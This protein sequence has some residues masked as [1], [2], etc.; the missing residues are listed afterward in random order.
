[1]FNVKQIIWRL[2][3]K[4]EKAYYL[5]VLRVLVSLWFIK[6]MFFRWPAFEMLYSNHSFLK[7]DATAS[8][9]AFGLNAHFLREHYIVLITVCMLLLL[10]NLFG[11]G[12]NITS[13]LLFLSFTVLY[14]LD[15]KFANSGDEMSML[16]LF[17]LSF[18]NSFSYFTL[19]KRKPFESQKE[20]VYNLISNLAAYSMMINLCLSYFMAGVF[21]SIDPYWRNGTGIYFFINDDRYSV[22]AAGGR[23]VAFPFILSAIIGYGT[24]LME[25]CFP[26]LVWYK[27][28]RNIIFTICLL[29]HLGI[30]AFLMIYGMTIIFIIQYGMFYTNEEV[31]TFV[32]KI[33]SFLRKLFRFA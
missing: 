26:F 14:H 20:K 13:F 1:L 15:N 18:S 24:I 4:N 16:L 7:L 6:E 33:K 31:I 3:Q 11:I 21:K 28:S 10:L 29:M 9:Q 30:Y 2:Q 8:L 22:F 32:E 23:H 27:K 25:L 5:A 12:R 19:F 17:Y